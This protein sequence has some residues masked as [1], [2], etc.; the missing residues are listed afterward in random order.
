MGIQQ[1]IKISTINKFNINSNTMLYLAGQKGFTAQIFEGEGGG[2]IR[3][4]DTIN[5]C[6]I[7]EFTKYI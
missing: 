6:N 3:D 4:A 5:K 1:N 2:E 7:S